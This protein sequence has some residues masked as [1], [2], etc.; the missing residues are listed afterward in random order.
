MSIVS[1]I[2]MMTL[3]LVSVGY[4]LTLKRHGSPHRWAIAFVV[5]VSITDFVY[6][7]HLFYIGV[8]T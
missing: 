5:L 7:A 2:I 1:P 4:V 3:N 8:T 6:G